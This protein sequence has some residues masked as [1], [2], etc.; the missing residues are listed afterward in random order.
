VA[1]TQKFSYPD[2]ARP[3][4]RCSRAEPAALTERRRKKPALMR[5]RRLAGAV[6]GRR[7]LARLTPV[8]HRCHRTRPLPFALRYHP[9]HQ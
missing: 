5:H 9:T 8:R 1:A 6:P 7:R 2:P 4:S 3:I